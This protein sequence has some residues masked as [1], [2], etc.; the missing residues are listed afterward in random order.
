VVS[1]SERRRSRTE[2]SGRQQALKEAPAAS[3]PQPRAYIQDQSR[4]QPPVGPGWPCSRLMALS[5]WPDQVVEQVSQQLRP[6]SSAQR[7]G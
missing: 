7:P 3:A 1:L 6:S 2:P 4:G 5:A